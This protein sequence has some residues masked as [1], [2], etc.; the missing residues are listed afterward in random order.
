LGC[1][2]DPIGNLYVAG[3]TA[4]ANFPVLGTPR[5]LAGGDD[6]FVLKFHRTGMPQWSLLYGGSAA[7]QSL[8]LTVDSAGNLVVVG[9]SGSSDFPA[10]AGAYQTSLAGL[11][12]GV[13]TRLG[14]YLLS[15]ELEPLPDTVLCTG[16]Y[17]RLRWRVRG[18]QFAAES[19]P[20]RASDAGGSFQAPILLDSVTARRDTALSV[21]VPAQ[22]PGG[23][24]RFRVAAT[25]PLAYSNDN[26]RFLSAQQRPREPQVTMDGDTVF[27]EG[28]RALLYIVEPQPGVR[29]RWWRDSAVV[30]ENATEYLVMES[31]TYTAEAYNA[32][33]SVRARRTFAITVRP[34]PRRPIIVPSDDVRVCSGDTVELRITGEPGV[35]YLWF[36][37]DTALAGARDTILRVWQT[38]TYT[39]E[40][41]NDCGAVRAQNSARV[42]VVPRPPKPL[43]G[44]R[45]DTL[46][47]SALSGNQ[48]LDENKQPI[49]GA[50]GR[51]FV[52]PH[53]GTYYV[54]V[55]VDS[56]STLSD[57]YVFVRSSVGDGCPSIP[58]WRVEPNP[59]T[60][61]L[62]ISI[63][64]LSGPVLLE[65][66]DI[67]GRSLHHQH[68][69]LS[70]GTTVDIG[71]V[72]WTRGVYSVCLTS[73]GLQWYRV[74]V[75][76]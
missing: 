73:K 14:G 58:R 19:L 42:R 16:D 25:Q 41:R 69:W 5:Q 18:G 9:S 3:R 67:F 70:Y 37:N 23:Q 38:G 56:C 4:S 63:E 10:T 28:R 6:F 24:Y 35:S 11:N 54:Q 75:K 21:F 1:A 71:I 39:V 72:R 22:P 13:V 33:G 17:L 60:E 32:C 7:E 51:E 52:P 64:G 34:L 12:D 44:R 50:V 62:R 15:L 46:V 43:I 65:V 49:P 53:D 20:C 48:W 76:Q 8:A 45:G 30:S 74:F 40:A 61:L 55:T 26:G 36:R 2:A 68:L 66:F 57:P 47:S 27:C 59:A 31:G 29:Y